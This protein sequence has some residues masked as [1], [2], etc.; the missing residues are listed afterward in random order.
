MAGVK[1]IRLETQIFENP[2]LLY[3]K[4][5]KQYKAI[6]AH[7]EAM[8]YSGRHGLAGYVP[9]AALRV[10]GASI[11]DA[12]RLVAAGLWGPAEGGWS[13]NGWEE[14]Q[15]ADEEAN[16][17]SEKAKKAAAARWAKRNGKEFT[18]A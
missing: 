6:V 3:L 8:T 11:H 7:L 13:I 12:N 17:R 5:D 9:K 18:D 16:K 10:L 2:K 1:W 15:L 14:Y 4:E